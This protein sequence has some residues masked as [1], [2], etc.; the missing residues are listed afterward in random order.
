MVALYLEGQSLKQAANALGYS[1]KACVTALSEAGIERRPAQQAAFRAATTTSLEHQAA[2]VADYLAGAS[3]R[4]AAQKWGYS[5]GACLG[6]LKRANISVRKAGP[7]VPVEIREAIVQLYLQGKTAGE[8]ASAFGYSDKVC[9]NALKEQGIASRPAKARRALDDTQEQQ[10]IELYQ[11]GASIGDIAS[12]MGCGATT[13]HTILS[14]RSI[15]RRPKPGRPSPIPQFQRD[16]M[17]EAY[18]SGLSATNAATLFGYSETACYNALEEKGIA[19]RELTKL[20]PAQILHVKQAYEQGE[21]PSAIALEM[22]VCAATI[23]KGLRKSGAAMRTVSE[24]NQK[25]IAPT[26]IFGE[27]DFKT[28]PQAK[29]RRLS[30]IGVCKVC[31][32]FLAGYGQHV[33]ARHAGVSK[34]TVSCLLRGRGLKERRG[35]LSNPE[36]LTDIAS[37]KTEADAEYYAAK[38]NFPLAVERTRMLDREQENEICDAYRQGQGCVRLAKEYEVCEATI[39]ASLR[40]RGI[41]PQNGKLTETQLQE[42]VQRYH[43]GEKMK[44]LGAEF[45]LASG[46]IRA[47]MQAR[48]IQRKPHGVDNRIYRCNHHFFSDIRS[49]VQAYFLGFLAAD[50][51][52]SHDGAIHI[53]LAAKDV[54][55]LHLFLSALESNHPIRLYSRRH[56]TGIGD[57]CSICV[58]SSQLTQDVA[59]FGLVPAKTFIVPWPALPDELSRHYLRGY[60][61]GDGCWSLDKP[62][63]RTPQAHFGL[64]GPEPFLVEAQKFLMEKCDLRLTKLCRTTSPFLLNLSYGGNLQCARIARLL[65]SDSTISLSRKRQRIYN[66]LAENSNVA[67]EEIFSSLDVNPRI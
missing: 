21:N 26:P 58:A 24:A 25:R 7:R 1:V 43:A 65:Y 59:R 49:E 39:L 57:Y 2:M 66:Y 10:V 67:V 64:V 41:E 19:R 6:A 11:N 9:F 16:A 38:F 42:V 15:E 4:E 14:R 17:V 62:T 60:F 8:A 13:V 31:L 53:Q 35:E 54:E 63:R 34:F 18:L 44:A 40:R 37:I 46:N 36:I 3:A 47:L 51:C 32:L 33:V 48:G 20:S 55:I 45:G 56:K 52:I 23:L 28:A 22:G 50:G 29:V 27:L 61:D 12:Q 30:P 5:E